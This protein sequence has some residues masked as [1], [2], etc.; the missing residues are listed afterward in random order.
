[1][2]GLLLNGPLGLLIK[3]LSEKE[4]RKAL[5]GSSVKIK[6]TDVVASF[7]VMSSFVIFP[8]ASLIYTLVFRL[9]LYH[10]FGVRGTALNLA[11]LLF[12][13]FWPLYSYGNFFEKEKSHNSHLAMVLAAD[14]ALLNYRNLK[15]RFILLIFR[16]RLNQIK[17][18][19]KDLVNRVKLIIDGFQH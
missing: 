7:K 3:Y 16:S 10:S 11:T 2:P 18:T 8:V 6:G 14:Q 12:I 13:L 5:A 19:R 1:M 4:R 15:A 17:E 9:V